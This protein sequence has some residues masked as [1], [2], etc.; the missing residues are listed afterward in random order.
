MM[1][2]SGVRIYEMPLRGTATWPVGGV[3]KVRASASP[4][5]VSVRRDVAA[6]AL[7]LRRPAGIDTDQALV[8]CIHRGPIAVAIFCRESAYR[9]VPAPDRPA[10]ETRA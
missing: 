5:S 8:P 2:L 10:Q 9:S 3:G 6:D 1:P 7:H 4:R